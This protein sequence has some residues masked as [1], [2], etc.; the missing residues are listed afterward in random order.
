M[1][2]RRNAIQICSQDSRSGCGAAIG[3]SPYI[4]AGSRRRDNRRERGLVARR[5]PGC[6]IPSGA[7]FQ[8][9]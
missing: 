2:R 6:V 3:Q 1:F 8:A 4:M 5:F 9:E 7:V